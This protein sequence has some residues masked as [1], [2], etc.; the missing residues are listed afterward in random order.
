MLP[1]LDGIL[2]ESLDPTIKHLVNFLVLAH[3]LAFFIFIILLVR[4][5]TKSSS[6]NFRDQVKQF[7]KS[8]KAD[9]NKKKKN[10]KE[11]WI[12]VN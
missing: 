8:A 6:D 12:S 2:P 1:L 9:Q 11:E 4:S 10:L 3:L 7:E 5:F